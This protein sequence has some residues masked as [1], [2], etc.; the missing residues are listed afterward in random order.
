MIQLL[1]VTEAQRLS[2][3]IIDVEGESLISLGGIENNII[4][5]MWD[6]RECELSHPVKAVD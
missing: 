4:N 1:S 2:G 6:T 5:G 3:V